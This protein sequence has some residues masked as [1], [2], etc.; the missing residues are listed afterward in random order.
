MELIYCFLEKV[1]QIVDYISR[2]VLVLFMAVMIAVVLLGIANR[3]LFHFSIS[4]VE[5]VATYLLIYIS[6]LGAGVAMRCGGHIGMTYLTNKLGDLK[7]YADLI[8]FMA[9]IFFLG[10]LIIY[11]AQLVGSQG[12]QK[13]PA[14]RISMTIPFSAI[15]IGSCIM[16][17][18]SL[19]ITSG[20]MNRI[21]NNEYRSERND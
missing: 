6:M 7:K 2:K 10:Y 13:S 15:P 12:F 9:V 17:F 11:G 20:I 8:G 1:S 19:A 3:F 5:E 14:L 21:I 16:L 4:W 18:H